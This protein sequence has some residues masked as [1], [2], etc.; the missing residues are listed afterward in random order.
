MGKLVSQLVTLSDLQ[1]LV[2]NG[3]PKK[4]EIKEQCP[5]IFEFCF[6]KDPPH[7]V[8]WSPTHSTGP[9]PIQLVP[10]H[11][12]FYRY[13]SIGRSNQKNQKTKS[14]YFRILLLEGPSPPSQLVP[15]PFNWSPNTVFYRYLSIG[16]SNKKNKKTKSIYFRILLLGGPF[17]PSQLVPNPFN[18]SPNTVFYRYLSICRSNKKIYIYPLISN[19]ASGR[20]LST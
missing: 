5:F 15:N 18:W 14:F 1:S 3:R 13:L 2:S 17:P 8:N 16:R 19:L 20:T 9:Q 4:K 7:P 10:K 6:W 11:C 12:F